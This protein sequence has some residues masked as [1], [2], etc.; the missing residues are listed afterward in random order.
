MPSSLLTE[1]SKTSARS[2]S[3]VACG[4]SNERSWQRRNKRGNQKVNKKPGV[5]SKYLKMK[6][7]KTKKRDSLDT[8]VAKPSNSPLV[9]VS[10]TI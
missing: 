4:K 7:H 2:P 1:L 6:I 9:V 5:K 10:T 8:Q 3:H